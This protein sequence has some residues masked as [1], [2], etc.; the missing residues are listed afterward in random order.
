LRRFF[1]RAEPELRDLTAQTA[2][3][4]NVHNPF[5]YG[6]ANFFIGQKIGLTALDKRRQ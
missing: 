3:V 6:S 4:V 2:Q 5:Y 1:R